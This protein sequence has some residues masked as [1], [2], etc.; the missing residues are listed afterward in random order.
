MELKKRTYTKDN[1]FTIS[2]DVPHHLLAYAVGVLR[3]MG[4]PYKIDPESPMYRILRE[5]HTEKYIEL[6][7]AREIKDE[8]P[9]EL[10]YRVFHEAGDADSITVNV[11]PIYEL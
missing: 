1:I 9:F 11:K 4:V 3:G 6:L 8:L 7:I 10:G 2:K 5:S